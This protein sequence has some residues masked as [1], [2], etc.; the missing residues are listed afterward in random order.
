MQEYGI[1][2]YSRLAESTA[3]DIGFYRCGIAYIYTKESSW[4]NAQP[5]IE[6][7][8][9]LG[10]ELEILD[11]RRASELLPLIRFDATKGIIFEAAAIRIRAADAIPALAEQ[12]A[13]AG[14]RFHYNTQVTGFE[15][16]NG[17]LHAVQT[18]QG[19][20]QSPQVVISAGAWSRALMAQFSLA[21]PIE[22][23]IQTRFT[24]PPLPGVDATLPLLIF[25][26]YHGMYMRE[27]RGGLLIGASDDPPW[28]SDRIGDPL[29]PPN[30]R[31]IVPDQGLRARDYLHGIEHLMPV[32]QQVEIEQIA[33]GMPCYTPDRL[34]I[35]DRVPDCEGLYLLAACNYSG[36]SHG[37][38]LG[39]LMAELM[40]DGN[41][42]WESESFQLSRF[43]AASV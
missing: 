8:R 3:R 17:R 34:F 32:L 1:D 26:D 6:A 30:T 40:V 15:A 43:T 22:P 14:V 16:E 19:R 31:E 28:P 27:E 12:L 20:F 36:I 41:T 35:A 24:T 38:A 18:T 7:A 29:H 39:R 2:F 23:V 25:S 5:R 33:S 21:C 10:T 37:P 9:A 4:A 42:T 11:E 13:Q